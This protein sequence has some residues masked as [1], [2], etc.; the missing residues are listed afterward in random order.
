M[1]PEATVRRS[2]V[3]PGFWDRYKAP[4]LARLSG[5]AVWPGCLAG[6]MVG[7]LFGA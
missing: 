5:R 3:C 4:R 2:R 1:R 6:L 7:R